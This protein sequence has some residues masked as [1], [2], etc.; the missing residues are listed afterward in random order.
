MELRTMKDGRAIA[1]FNV[2]PAPFVLCRSTLTLDHPHFSQALSASR[3]EQG[4]TLAR[5]AE[6]I[7]QHFHA[8]LALWPVFCD[9]RTAGQGEIARFLLGRLRPSY[10]YETSS[11]SKLVSLLTYKKYCLINFLLRH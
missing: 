6:I 3:L 11:K 10:S 5:R 7:A 9:A 2:L 8:C 4:L 1:G